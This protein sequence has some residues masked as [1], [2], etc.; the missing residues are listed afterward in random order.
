MS[1]VQ[2]HRYAF[3]IHNSSLFKD[4]SG[5]VYT[6]LARSIFKML[7]MRYYLIGDTI[8]HAGDNNYDFYILLDGEVQVVDLSG[9]K[10]LATLNTGSHF[11]EANTLFNWT[12][13]RTAS[14][15]STTISEIGFISNQKFEMLLYAFPEWHEMLLKIAAERM[16]A[17]FSATDM[18]EVEKKFDYISQ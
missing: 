17:T 9:K 16:Q 15:V 18:E 5:F 3:A 6:Q 2:M 8:I 13:I 12:R 14:V 10:V 11:G 4:S 1:D 7:N